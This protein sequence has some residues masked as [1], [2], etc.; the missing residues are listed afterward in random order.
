MSTLIAQSRTC[1]YNDSVIS[2]NPEVA[3]CPGSVVDALP[4]KNHTC[5]NK[6]KSLFLVRGQR[7]Y[8]SWLF[9]L[10]YNRTSRKRFDI[11][12]STDCVVEEEVSILAGSPL[13]GL[14]MKISLQCGAIAPWAATIE[15]PHYMPWSSNEAQYLLRILRNDDLVLFQKALARG[16]LKLNS[17]FS[18]DHD[19]RPL[20]EVS[21]D[22][23]FNGP[24]LS[25]L[26]RY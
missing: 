22:S 9:A 21:E 11:S 23:C 6:A 26:H 17:V 16:Q 12:G 13:C 4:S 5:N 14:Y 20:F 25:I 2:A 24:N 18:Y 19:D 8:R 15:I 10:D 3:E 7:Q 1:R